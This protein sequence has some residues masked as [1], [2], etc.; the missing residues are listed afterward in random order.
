MPTT[1]GAVRCRFL[2]PYTDD[3]LKFQGRFP[4]YTGTG[5]LEL[6]LGLILVGEGFEIVGIA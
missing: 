3:S 2:M 1:P 5:R 6:A 4:T